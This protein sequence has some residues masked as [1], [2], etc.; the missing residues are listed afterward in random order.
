MPDEETQTKEATRSGSFYCSVLRT[1]TGS[2]PRHVSLLERIVRTV[3]CTSNV[4][5]TVV[6]CGSGQSGP[7]RPS[8][9]AA[10]NTQ[11]CWKTG[12]WVCASRPLV[13]CTCFAVVLGRFCLSLGLCYRV[14]L[15]S[16]TNV[17]LASY[18]CLPDQS[19]S[20]LNCI[21][22]CS[23]L[24]HFVAT[25]RCYGAARRLFACASK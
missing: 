21:R 19:H 12:T 13:L 3:D 23:F 9:T 24:L 22:C 16:R 4:L 20:L 8:W 6:G 15:R 5:T 1:T 10:S 7:V 11:A 18:T 17:G 25:L 2:R 14:L